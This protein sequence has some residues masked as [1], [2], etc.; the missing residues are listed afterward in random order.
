LYAG[1]LWEDKLSTA[2]K[3][4]EEQLKTAAHAAETA[5]DKGI[6]AASDAVRAGV[7]AASRESEAV[8][9]R[10]TQFYETGVAHY[11]ATEQQALDA[12]KRGISFVRAE[13]PEASAALGV[14]A[15][16]TLL[17]GPRRFLLRHTIG[18]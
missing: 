14:A 2:N 4:W 6:S 11:E 3:A 1:K 13:H 12:L 15:F 10:L 8:K 9:S 5:V 7:S 16:F 17:R 18:R